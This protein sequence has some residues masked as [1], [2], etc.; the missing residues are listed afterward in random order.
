MQNATNERI[1]KLAASISQISSASISVYPWFE[2]SP[3]PSG[4]V[5][6]VQRVVLPQNREQ[7]PCGFLILEKRRAHEKDAK[8]HANGHGSV[9][10]PGICL[11]ARPCQGRNRSPRGS[12]ISARCSAHLSHKSSGE[13][14]GGNWP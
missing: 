4:G 11:N 5:L 14:S 13:F 1:G 6:W 8:D 2:F 12:R 3:L 7:A 10:S 9:K